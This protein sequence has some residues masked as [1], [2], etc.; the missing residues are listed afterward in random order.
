MTIHRKCSICKKCTVTSTWLG[1]K[2]IGIF[3]A[4]ISSLEWVLAD[5]LAGHIYSH[6]LIACWNTLVRLLLFLIILTIFS[7]LQTA[8]KKETKLSSSDH[9][10]GVYNARFFEEHAL[11]E[12][13]RSKRYNH[14]LT[15]VYLDL[16][17]FKWVNDNLGH[18]TGD[19]LL[20]LLGQVI[21]NNIRTIDVVARMGG[22]EFV[23]LFPETDYE[24]AQELI[25]R[26]RLKF[27]KLMAKHKW[28]VTFSIGMITFE[29]PPISVDQIIKEADD[30][31]YLAKKRGKNKIEHRIQKS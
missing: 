21:H 8:L 24:A 27:G 22:D 14:P 13:H 17:N 5:I 11:I 2:W 1:N 26:M 19:T 25:E 29:S 31:M 16:D 18:Q 9:L 28:P 4:V 12:I 15:V 30:L 7:E 20:K 10:T 3:F 23:I 6:P